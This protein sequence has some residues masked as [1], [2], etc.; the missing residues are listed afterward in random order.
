M[1][2]LISIIVPT[3]NSFKFLPETIDGVL[4][5]TY[6][7]FEI[8]VI[9]D[10]ST[11]GTEKLFDEH[12]V[13][14]NNQK[15]KYLRLEKN[16]GGPAGPRN[17]GID[18]AK[19]EYICFLDSDD[20]WMPEKLELQLRRM[21]SENL[22][23]TS[24]RRR[25]FN[26][27]PDKSIKPKGPDIEISYSSLLKKNLIFTSSVMV[28][29]SLIKPLKFDTQKDRIAVE[30]YEMWLSILKLNKPKALILGDYLIYYR[31]HA[32]GISKAKIKMAKKVWKLLGSENIGIGPI[33]RAYCFATYAWHS[34]VHK[35]I[36]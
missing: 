19:G 15:I 30:D 27:T 33:K 12:S 14:F 18:I 11:D 13:Y 23:F 31:V 34:T 16:F 17:K 35:L 6:Q 26:Y 22:D 10:K 3:Y 24:T 4:N 8:L 36:E 25:I 9:D 1:T 7:N 32:N 20:I 21:Q 29:A 5:Q 2:P 28:K